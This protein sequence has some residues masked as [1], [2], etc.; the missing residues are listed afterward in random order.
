MD[1]ACRY[2]DSPSRDAVL[3]LALRVDIL[4]GASVSRLDYKALCKRAAR[5]VETALLGVL[6]DRRRQIVF[7]F[8]AAGKTVTGVAEHAAGAPL[9]TKVDSQRN[10]KRL[11]AQAISRVL[12]SPRGT[13]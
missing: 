3:L 10:G 8:N 5:Y 6:H 7:G 2:D 13:A 11:V 9:V 1:S 12:Q 4:H